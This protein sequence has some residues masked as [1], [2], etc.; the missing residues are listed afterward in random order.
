[1]ASI[2]QIGRVMV[3]VESQDAAIA[4]YTGTLGFNVVADVPFGDGDRWV[5]VAPPAGGAAVALVPPQGDYQAG[6]NTGIALE[7][8]DA[9]AAHDEL[10]AKGVDVDA[11]LM[12]GD[13]TV[14]MLFFF[15][16]HD[17][18]TLMIVE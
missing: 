1:M 10:K 17:A 2:T 11:E 6:R 15:R 7:T 3:P 9:R 5:E 14:P 13:G 12:G 16:D 18:N 4:F 8:T